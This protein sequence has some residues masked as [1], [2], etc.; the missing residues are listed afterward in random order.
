MTG[1]VKQHEYT[2]TVD[3]RAFSPSHYATSCLDQCTKKCIKSLN[4]GNGVIVVLIISGNKLVDTT[5]NFEP[6][7]ASANISVSNC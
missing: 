6:V 7:P 2:V 5:R 4:N 1:L 3:K